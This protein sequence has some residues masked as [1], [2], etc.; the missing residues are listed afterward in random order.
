MDKSAGDGADSAEDSGSS[1]PYPST[2]PGIPKACISFFED[3]IAI[4]IKYLICCQSH[5]TYRLTYSIFNT[6]HIKP[7]QCKTIISTSSR[8]N[9]GGYNEVTF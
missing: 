1:Q 5:G 2:L 6:R 7:G 8:T 3:L 9:G 4:A